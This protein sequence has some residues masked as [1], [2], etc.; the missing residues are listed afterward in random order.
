MLNAERDEP[1]ER[2]RDC[3][4]CVQTGYAHAYL[5]PRVEERYMQ[6]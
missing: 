1:T 4:K 5:V 3:V 6:C 2:A